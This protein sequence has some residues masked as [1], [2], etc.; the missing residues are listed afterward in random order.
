MKQTNHAQSLSMGMLLLGGGASAARG[1][2]YLLGTEQEGLLRRGHPCAVVLGI[3][4]V[5]AV[6]AALLQ[7]FGKPGS[8]KW[9][10]TFTPG[11][12]SALGCAVMAFCIAQT[13][14][15]GNGT[16]RGNLALLWEI[17]G[18]LAAAGLLWA[19]FS[20][21]KGKKPFLPVYA[22]VC[23]FLALHMVSRYQVWSG[24]PQVMDWVFSLLATVG[25]TLCAYQLAALCADLGHRR[26][27]LAESGLTVFFCCAALPGNDALWLYLGGLVW[28]FTALWSVTP[29]L[30][31]GQEE[32]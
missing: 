32:G 21:S 27:F 25:L 3:L 1:L 20:Q 5:A 9:E 18:L 14:V 6:V 16:A 28:M 10:D 2:Y 4:C 23:L 17:S 12:R 24:D 26:T 30:P 19:A 15:S 13:V 22:L 8:G 7:L 31:A 29:V 11:K